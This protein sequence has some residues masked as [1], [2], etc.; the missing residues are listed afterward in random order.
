[1]KDNMPPSGKRRREHITLLRICLLLQM[2]G[3]P[4]LAKK[5]DIST[6]VVPNGETVC[7]WQRISC[8]APSVS[9]GT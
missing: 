3:V 5:F 6:K 4:V 2:T 9:E 7:E 8:A 1:M